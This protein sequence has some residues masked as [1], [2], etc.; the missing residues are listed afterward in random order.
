ML[1]F[2]LFTFQQFDPVIEAAKNGQEVDLSKMPPSLK[3]AGSSVYIFYC[4][5]CCG[6]KK[7]KK[8]KARSNEEMRKTR[9][10]TIRVARLP[11][12]HLRW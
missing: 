8:Q 4:H 5:L 2:Y 6:N 9:I 10:A 12:L 1:Y 3:S 7:V 11:S